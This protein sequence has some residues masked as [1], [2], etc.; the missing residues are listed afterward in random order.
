MGLVADREEAELRSAKAAPL[1]AP[2]AS[3]RRRPLRLTR[4]GWATLLALVA[5]WWFFP[6]GRG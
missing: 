1:P 6:A 2:R 3:P 5:M 4:R